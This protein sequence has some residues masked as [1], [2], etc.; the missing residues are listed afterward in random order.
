[1][2]ANDS[3]VYHIDEDEKMDCNNNHICEVSP[4]TDYAIQ[5]KL[6]PKAESKVDALDYIIRIFSTSK[7]IHSKS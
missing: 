7:F 5:F 1:M 3:V 6:S 4:L 2:T